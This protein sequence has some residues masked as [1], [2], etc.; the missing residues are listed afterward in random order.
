M[1]K[2]DEPKTAFHTRF[3]LY[4]WMVM[5]FGLC[6]ALATFQA[7]IDNLF[8]DML[9][10]GVIIYRNNIL[11]YTENMTE[12]QQLVKEVL[13]RLSKA[14]LSINAKTRQWYS[15]KVEFLE[16]IIFEDGII[17]SAKKMQVVKH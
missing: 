17:M 11:I 2:A 7:M 15:S 9:N 13:R 12:Y 10:E 1:A 4:E 6:N 5:P 8:Y 16:Y 14:S 3:G